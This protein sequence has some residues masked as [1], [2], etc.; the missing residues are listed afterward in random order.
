MILNFSFYFVLAG[1]TKE[2]VCEVHPGSNSQR[3]NALYIALVLCGGV[4]VGNSFL[5]RFRVASWL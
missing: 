2:G 3:I 4:Y 5:V 1:S